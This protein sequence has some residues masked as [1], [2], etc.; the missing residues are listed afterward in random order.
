MTV[1][2]SKL[3]KTAKAAT[4]KVAK[5][6]AKKAVESTQKTVKKVAKTAS[7]ATKTAK[8]AATKVTKTTA[9]KTVAKKDAKEK[10]VFSI[11]APLATTVSIAGCFNEWNPTK[12][13]LKKGKDGLWSI[14]LSLEPGVYEYK[15]VCDSVN[16]D[17]GDNKIKNV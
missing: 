17:E 11:D 14:T 7:A 2:K 4:T 13:K 3:T 9:K 12:N 6:A 10:V 1:K 16:W 15:F 8:A 5:T